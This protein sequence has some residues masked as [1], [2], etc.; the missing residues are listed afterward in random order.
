MFSFILFEQHKPV[1][2]IYHYIQREQYKY[3]NKNE[4]KSGLFFIKIYE[5]IHT[6]WQIIQYKIYRL[7]YINEYHKELTTIHH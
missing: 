5:M 7:K 4:T 6:T 1:T 3:N 2:K